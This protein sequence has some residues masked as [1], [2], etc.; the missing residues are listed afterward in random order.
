[1][2]LL[3]WKDKRLR[4]AAWILGL[5]LFAAVARDV[6][7]N[8]RP[9]YCRIAGK[10]WF[11]GLRSIVVDP[12]RSFGDP[13][14]DSLQTNELWKQVEYDAA[15]FA[16]VPF[17][18]GEIVYGQRTTFA[19][20]RPG[21]VHPG[22]ARPFR[23]W[24]GTDADGRD[25]AAGLISGARVALVTGATAMSLAFALGL[26]LG[27][28]AGYC[29]DDRL[30]LP[31]GALALGLLA[32]P[33]AWFY[34]T[35]PGLPADGPST[36][37]GLVAAAGFLAVVGLAAALGRW[38][39]RIVPAFGRPV[40]V[41][42]DLLIMRLAELFNAVPKL[43]VVI[44]IAGAYENPSRL[45]MIALLGVLSWTSVARYVRAELLRVR[46]LEYVTA[47]RGFGLR[48]RR[49]LLRHA[50]PNALGPALIAFA[51]GIGNAI[52]LEAALSLLGYGSPQPGSMSWGTLLESVRTAPGNWW[53]VLPAG[54]AIGLTVM[55]FH[56]VGEALARRKE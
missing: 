43:I 40:T 27:A 1:M 45:L 29:G 51:F 11:P 18:P 4:V 36:G 50:L 25:V 10:T 32:L 52:V 35:V 19:N 8:G 30:R 31:R 22:L 3:N 48:E 20:Q 13:L 44:V 6:L 5:L 41:P 39:G 16:P 55:A 2:S 12:Y 15:V 49:V 17:S 34:A 21:A 54:L 24:L 53:V 7:A 23:H 42:A 56:F 14:L 46:E 33:L 28:L 47:A 26:V 9:L 37:R 38:L